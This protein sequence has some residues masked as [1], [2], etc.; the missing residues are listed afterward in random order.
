MQRIE[1]RICAFVLAA[2]T[3]LSL[4]GCGSA[5]TPVQPTQAATEAV[6]AVVETQSVAAE[7][8]ATE[9][10]EPAILEGSLF[11]KVSSITFSLTGESEDV[12][13]GVVPREL[14]T[15]ESENP[16]IVSV[17]NG[18]LTAVG[19]GT[20]VIHASYDDRQASCIAGCLAQTREELEALDTEILSAPK[21]L[22]PEVD[23]DEPCTY[24]DNA[25]IVGDSITYGMMQ[26]EARS[27]DLGNILFLSRGGIG[28]M[29]F[30][31]R[32]KNIIYQGYELELEDIIEKT[33]VERVFFLVGSNDI[34]AKYE[35]DVMMENWEIILN[36]IWEKTP[37]VEIVLMSSIPRYEQYP[38]L[39]TPDPYNQL[40]VAYNTNLRQFAKEHGC[41]FL[42]LHS[43]IQD[44]WGRLPEIYRIDETHLSE[45]G[46]TNWMKIMRYYARYESEGGILE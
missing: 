43:Y 23:L 34:A 10:T 6:P 7:V 28:M 12:Y 45:L 22:P 8:P 38:S 46:C 13:L 18:V 27:N 11:L 3:L 26:Y 31:K 44:H 2:A 1:K 21:W 37:D 14:V 9:E 17:E 20:T 29:G 41:M 32:N 25:A 15:W 33:G 40:T 24:F 39:D 4:T 16:D 30:V 36:R 19:V 35:M 42:D 5:D